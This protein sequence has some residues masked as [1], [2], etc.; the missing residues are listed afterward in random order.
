[1]ASKIDSLKLEPEEY[2]KKGKKCK[3]TKGQPHY[4]HSSMHL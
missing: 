4:L 1:M 3:E 2:L